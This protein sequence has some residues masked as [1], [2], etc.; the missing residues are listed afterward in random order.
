MQPRTEI[1]TLTMNSSDRRSSRF[2][3]EAQDVTGTHALEARDVEQA[4]PA[5]TVARALAAKMSLPD[6]VPWT[7]RD[8][9]TG[10]YLEEARPIGEQIQSGAR[11]QLTPKTHLGGIHPA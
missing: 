6:N 7:L 8:E 10:A 11:V 3:F 1:D 5:G 9:Q 4:T 2:T